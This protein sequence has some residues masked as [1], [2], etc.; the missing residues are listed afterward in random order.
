MIGRGFLT[1]AVMGIGCFHL[2]GWAQQA[3]SID[4]AEIQKHIDH[5]VPPIYPPIAKAAH[6]QGT[7][8]FELRIG[9]SGKI[10]SMKVASGPAM[11]QQAAIDCLKQWTFRPF[12][13]DGA[14]VAVTGHMPIVFV[15]SDYHPGSD[16]EKIA[17]RY[18]KQED[19]C[20]AVMKSQPDSKAAASACEEAA[21]TAEEFGPEVR[22]IEKRSAFVSAAWALGNAG[23]FK[24]GLEWADKAEAVDKLGHDDNSGKNGVYLVKGV[25]EGNLGDLK[26]ADADFT[27]ADDFARRAIAWG[28]SVQF[29]HLDS[30]ERSLVLG[31]RLHAQL[32]QALGRNE[33]AQKLLKE[34]QEASQ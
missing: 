27:S 15:L 5:R 1:M 9:T 14:P 22:F 13:K 10:E 4:P 29:E 18:F 21:K 8:D 24:G 12:E 26:T 3:V 30:Y 31:L 11:L 6:I 17:D 20:R 23:D 7:V 34:A 2:Q 16:D 32:L 28:K 25:L 19:E 33:D